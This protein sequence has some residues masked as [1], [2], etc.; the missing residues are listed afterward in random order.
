MNYS[1]LM[2]NDLQP[3]KTVKNAIIARSG[4][5]LYD[6][7]QIDTSLFEGNPHQI[8]GKVKINRS[9]ALIAAIAEMT[10]SVYFTREHPNEWV[11]PDN[12]KTY[13]QGILGNSA[14]IK[15][16]PNG[17]IGV[18][19]SIIFFSQDIY[20]Y[21]LANKEV[22]L[23]SRGRTRWID[24][25][26]QK[27]YDAEIYE[28]TG[29]NHVA[30]TQKGRGGY[31]VRI[32]DSEKTVHTCEQQGV[33]MKT[34]VV[35]FFKGRANKQSFTDSLLQS[36]EKSKSDEKEKD[37]FL[38][39]LK[40]L[41]D[42]KDKEYLLDCVSDAFTS[43]DTF[44]DSSIKKDITSFFDS[45]YDKAVKSDKIAALLDS[46]KK[47]DEEK[48]DEEKKDGKKDDDKKTETKDSV[49]A[50]TLESLKK[51]IEQMDKKL[52]SFNDSLEKEVL[53]ELVKHGAAIQPAKRDDKVNQFV[54]SLMSEVM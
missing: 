42:G 49:F 41:E 6:I 25:W 34:N 23:G 8:S 28:I 38:D 13:A 43:P 29:V 19:N 15:G 5:Q 53:K 52:N 31:D 18:Y 37:G 50:E 21:Y 2:V 36:L 35:S 51:S 47:D 44:L 46:V 17:E 26:E 4:V 1:Y 54:D 16:L 12:Y 27:G 33:K 20:E 7:T 45:A 9:P 3:Y 32:Y 48:K 11:S 39:S 14:K 40:S 10:N 22:S 30:L 24:D